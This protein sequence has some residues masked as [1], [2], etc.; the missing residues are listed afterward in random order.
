MICQI[1]KLSSLSTSIR[2]MGLLSFPLYCPCQATGQA[3]HSH[4][5]QSTAPE[6][7]GK[8]NSEY[9]SLIAFISDR[10]GLRSHSIC[11]QSSTTLQNRFKHSK[12]VDSL[13]RMYETK[14]VADTT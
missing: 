14:C 10:F 4:P 12:S 1:L 2:N 7:P 5:E 6:H 13:S 9:L 11:K 8:P 3:F